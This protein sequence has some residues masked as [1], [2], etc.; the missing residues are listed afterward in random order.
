M[1]IDT[2]PIAST[3]VGTLPAPLGKIPSGLGWIPDIP[4]IRDYTP[5]HDQVAPL[6]SRTALGASRN[7]AAIAAL[8]PSVDLRT[9]FSP[10]HDQGSL[11]SCTAHAADSLVEYFERRSFGSYIDLSRR[12]V[13]KVT[14]EM[15]G[16]T[17]DTGAT[18]RGTMGTLALFGAPPEK[19]WGYDIAQF[20]EEPSA[21]LYALA[22]NYKA[23]T[24]YRLDPPGTDLSTLLDRIRQF[25]SSGL[26]PMFGFT[27]YDSI[28]QADQTGEI[29]FPA[30]A[31]KVVGGHAIAVAGY[32][33]SVTITNAAADAQTTT[34]ALLIKNSWG[35][36]WGQAG[37]GWLPYEYVLSG[38]TGDWWSLIKSNWVDTAQFGLAD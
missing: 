20:E 10:V 16:W 15:L 34:G 1:L 18:I 38:L 28:A 17:G 36:T 7:G 30:G 8:P 27:V 31:D 13:Y 22:A 6:L 14:R 37:Y 5:T 29:P 23:I 12:F 11:G 2:K 3:R 19:Y 26:P 32:D 4:D 25:V 9:W 35:D 21:L 24:Y 33:D